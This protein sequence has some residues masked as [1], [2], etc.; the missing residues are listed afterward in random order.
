MNDLS[1]EVKEILRRIQD[2]NQKRIELQEDWYKLQARLVELQEA[3]ARH[4]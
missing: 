3:E 1:T 4:G 2:N